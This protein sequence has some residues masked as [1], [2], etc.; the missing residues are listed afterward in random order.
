MWSTF[1]LHDLSTVIR[2][3]G[4]GVIA[5]VLVVTY[6]YRFDAFS[7]SVF[8]IDAVLLTAAIVATRSSFRLFGRMVARVSPHRQ[9]VAIYGAGVR[10]QMLV[11]QMLTDEG[12]GRTPIAFIDDDMSKRSRR[13]VGVPVRG[14]SAELAVLLGRLNIEEIV[15]SSPA[16]DG[17]AE[18]RVR[19]IAA[20]RAV[21]VRRL[22]FEI[23]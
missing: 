23:R 6:L 21:A 12:W 11:R 3:V 4:S 14:T 16:I 13:L 18:A 20:A 19:A 15:I 2:A 10:G 17:E 22:F 7:R 9:R 5:S 8:V 1:G